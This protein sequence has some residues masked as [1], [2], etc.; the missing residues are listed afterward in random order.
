MSVQQVGGVVWFTP[1]EPVQKVER[2]T[3]E[4]GEAVAR[5]PEG[6]RNDAKFEQLQAKEAEIRAQVEAEHAAQGDRMRTPEEDEKLK[7][8]IAG[9]VQSR[10][11][12]ILD[13]EAE[14][15]GAAGGPML[16]DLRV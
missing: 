10:F 11:R 3:P 6:F 16:V 4:P 9:E 15:A 1:V 2:R 13:R 14:A 5:S 8:T 12:E 7:K